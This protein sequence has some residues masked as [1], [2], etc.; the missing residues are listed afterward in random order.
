MKVLKLGTSLVQHYSCNMF[1]GL[2]K[3]QV[4]T[5]PDNGE[6]F[7]T[8]R[9]VYLISRPSLFLPRKYVGR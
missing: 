5:N 2:G 9:K 4:H 3:Y 6:E 1:P 7:F 8:P